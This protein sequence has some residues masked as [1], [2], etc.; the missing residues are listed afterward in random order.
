LLL[1]LGFSSGGP[2]NIRKNEYILRAFYLYP[3]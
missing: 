1:K 2:F 3:K